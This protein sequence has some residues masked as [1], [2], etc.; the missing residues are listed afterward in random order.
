M[1]WLIFK[2][3]LLSKR[4]SALIRSIAWLC[5]S[6]VGIGV[7]A[8]TVVL[9]VMNGFDLAI[10]D[11]LLAVE[12]HLVVHVT[13][14]ANHDEDAVVQLLAGRGQAHP[15]ESRDVIVRTIDGLYGGAVAK[16]VDTEALTKI[17]RDVSKTRREQQRDTGPLDGVES[18]AGGFRLEPG[19]ISMGVDLANS[20]G[21][22]E[23]DEVVLATPEAL[24]LP[25]GEIPTYEK[26]RV[27]NFIRTN[28]P[29]IDSEMIFY[30][31]EAGL[32][33]LQGQLDRGVEIRLKD[34][35]DYTDLMN[36]IV[37]AGY[38]VESWEQ[39][40]SALFHSLRME[41]MAIG[42]FLSLSIIIASF[43]IITVL[44]LL[45]T[46][47][48]SEIGLLMAMGLA[49]ARTRNIFAGVGLLL[50]SIGLFGGLALG[51][52]FCIALDKFSF[53]R[54]P[55]VYYDTRI[56]VEIDYTVL[57]GMVGGSLVLALAASWIPALLTTRMSPTEAIRSIPAERT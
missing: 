57:A 26:V 22:F 8:M 41:K 3:Y 11:R 54:L 2:H 32:R 33:R 25:S 36:E 18:A 53:I 56:P 43:S 4:S 28:V 7:L 17:L 15:F 50:S 20:I 47:K 40:N 35:S 52:L 16:G 23:G 6:G 48:R 51:V 44:V 10:R 34:P 19:E 14:D 1:V 13:P 24:L 12:P 55:D 9:S 27:K 31:R 39:R 30:S 29:D 5:I 21:V 49:P 45:V 42:L 38:K 46:H 37:H